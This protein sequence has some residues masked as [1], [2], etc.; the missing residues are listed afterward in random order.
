MDVENM[1]G[2]NDL[3]GVDVQGKEIRCPDGAV[4]RVADVLV[5]PATDRPSHLVW[6]EALVVTKEV[7]IPIDYVERIEGDRVVLRVNREA[8]ERL[9]HFWMADPAAAAHLSTVEGY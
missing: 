6:R 7:S 2:R 9:P 4:G 3:I 8:I 1:P 5:D